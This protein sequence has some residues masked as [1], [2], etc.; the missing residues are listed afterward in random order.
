MNQFIG[1]GS[2]LD[3]RHA[4]PGR[5]LVFGAG[6]RDPDSLPDVSG[7]DW[8]IAFVRGPNTAAA[9]GMH[10]A[11]WISDP[12]IIVPLLDGGRTRPGPVSLPAGN[13]LRVGFIPYFATQRPFAEAIA[14]A[15]GLVFIPPTLDPERFLA[16][17]LA[18]DVVIAEAMHG[19]ILAD[20]FGVPWLACRISSAR[21]EGAT[22]AFKWTDWGQSLD[23]N[24]EFVDLPYLG[25]RSG[26]SFSLDVLIAGYVQ[27][28]AR[29][30]RRMVRE[31]GWQLSDR[32]I[33]E[34]RQRSILLAVEDTRDL[35]T[36]SPGWPRAVPG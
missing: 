11:S 24:I 16:R 4:G 26:L 23:L 5:K 25:H 9:L 28:G 22:H 3:D 15:A 2:I 18:C 14:N 29:I 13:R 35:L 8:H 17:L 21:R 30:L 1:I 20:A 36:Q 31:G 10:N 27:K 34:D 6:A 19:A 32:A 33:L 7:D 12:A